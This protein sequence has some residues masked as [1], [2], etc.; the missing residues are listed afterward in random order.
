MM[1]PAC[2]IK[3]GKWVMIAGLF[4]HV[5]K[6]GQKSGNFIAQAYAL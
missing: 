4:S 5:V 3:K 1:K 6:Q 2:E